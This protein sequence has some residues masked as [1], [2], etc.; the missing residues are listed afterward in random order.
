MLR[1]A[2]NQVEDI[3][4]H[5]M[6]ARLWQSSMQAEGANDVLTY[7]T[8]CD[9][10]AKRLK[11]ANEPMADKDLQSI[12]VAGLCDKHGEIFWE[13]LA[14]HERAPAASFED[15]CRTVKSFISRS[16]VADRLAALKHKPTSMGSSFPLAVQNPMSP[17]TKMDVVLAT[18][19]KLAGIIGG[20]QEGKSKA[21]AKAASDLKLPCYLHQQLSGSCNRE[22]CRFGP[23]GHSSGA[24]GRSVGRDEAKGQ[25]VC[26]VH[27]PGHSDAQCKSKKNPNRPGGQNKQGAAADQRGDAIQKLLL[28]LSGNSGSYGA[29]FSCVIIH[30]PAHAFSVGPEFAVHKEVI[31]I[32]NCANIHCA[33]DMSMAVPGTIE[34]VSGVVTGCGRAKVTHHF[35]ACVEDFEDPLNPSAP[36]R[37]VELKKVHFIEGLA[38]RLIVS[39]SILIGSKARLNYSLLSEANEELGLRAVSQERF[40]QDSGQHVM[41]ART[42]PRTGLMQACLRQKIDKQTNAKIA[43]PAIKYDGKQL[44]KVELDRRPISMRPQSGLGAQDAVG[45][46]PEEGTIEV[47]L[48][49]ARQTAL[50]IARDTELLIGLHVKFQHKTSFAGWANL[51]GIALPPNLKCLLCFTGDPRAAPVTPSTVYWNYKRSEA[52]SVDWVPISPTSHEGY[53][54]YFM[55]ADVSTR[56]IRH[57]FAEGQRAWCAIWRV[58]VALVEAHERNQRPGH[59]EANSRSSA[60]F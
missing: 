13:I 11:T 10:T 39:Q 20:K 56:M 1:M 54:G 8:Y 6:R 60:V 12:F 24:V 7:M 40:L 47:K 27:G 4:P 36:S 14:A 29:D 19:G 32:D 22:N 42:H 44:Q 48:P 23:Q 51:L 16:T 50:S 45:V 9:A 49:N 43:V 17:N 55:I 38:F 2:V 37:I 52:F 58:F 35:T 3:A 28:Q 41:T 59:K 15:L 25:G 26:S 18:V 46:E 21:A 5:T 57:I 34:E 33:S 53:N 30:L 31:L